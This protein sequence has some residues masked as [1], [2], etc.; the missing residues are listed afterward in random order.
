MQQ[1]LKH[2][3]IPEHKWTV[4]QRQQAFINANQRFDKIYGNMS[5]FQKLPRQ[6]RGYSTDANKP[7]INAIYSFIKLENTVYATLPKSENGILGEGSFGKV[8]LAIDEHGHKYAIK[9]EKIQDAGQKNLQIKLDES[10]HEMAITTDLGVGVTQYKHLSKEGRYKKIYSV[11][12]HKGEQ[13]YDFLKENKDKLTDEQRLDIAIK[14]CKAVDNLHSGHSSKTGQVYAHCD[15]KPQNMTI[16]SQLNISLV[17]FDLSTTQIDR[18]AEIQGTPAFLPI[19]ITQYT[20]RKI[21]KFGL[22]RILFYHED[23]IGLQNASLNPNEIQSLLTKACIK[24]HPL[25]EDVLS[26]RSSKIDH[27]TNIST[28]YQALHLAKTELNQGQKS[29]LHLLAK[30]KILTTHYIDL[31]AAGKLT[32]DEII[33]HYQSLLLTQH[34]RYDTYTIK[35]LS[36]DQIDALKQLDHYEILTHH[37]ANKVIDNTLSLQD[38]NTQQTTLVMTKHLKLSMETVKS[39]TKNQMR[40]VAYNAIHQAIEYLIGG[41]LTSHTFEPAKKQILDDLEQQFLTALTDKD[42]PKSLEQCLEKFIND[43]KLNEHK[44]PIL[45]V[46]SNVLYAFTGIGTAHMIYACFNRSSREAFFGTSRYQTIHQVFSDMVRACSD[47]KVANQLLQKVQAERNDH[48]EEKINKW[49]YVLLEIAG[50]SV[51]VAIASKIPNLQL[52]WTMMLII[53][54]SLLFAIGTIIV[55]TCLV[56]KEHSPNQQ[57]PSTLNSRLPSTCQPVTSHQIKSETSTTY[58]GSTDI[59]SSNNTLSLTDSDDD[60]LDYQAR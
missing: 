11:M 46:I 51:G 16:D 52:G 23:Y 19:N 30:V 39:L 8:R 60:S 24:Q 55:A 31:V 17:D 33:E 43:H 20:N 49:M 26:T 1:Q 34:F 44:N 35:H 29:A 32:K 12:H 25:L 38:I 48:Q 28:I 4:A 27:S 2:R 18:Q 7:D 6:R 10:N 50:G 41:Q 47:T 13:L 15:L 57:D 37:Y 21:D 45:D 40:P 9:V 3:A 56:N 5:D 58:R 14:V 54:F 42:A 22:K 53:G 59:E 36:K